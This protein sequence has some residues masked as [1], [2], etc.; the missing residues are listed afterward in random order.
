MDALY[1]NEW[2]VQVEIVLRDG[3]TVGER[4]DSVT[5]CPARPMTDQELA[6]KF[7]G[8]AQPILGGRAQQ[9]LDAC[10]DLEGVVDMAELVALLAPAEPPPFG[11]LRAG[12]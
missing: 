8:N 5:G 11:R 6:A 1:P 12:A 2:P 4:L 7:M 9:V 10:M 3:R